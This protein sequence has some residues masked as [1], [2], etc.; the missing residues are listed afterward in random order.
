MDPTVYLVFAVVFFLQ[1]PTSAVVY[2]DAKKRKLKHPGWYELGVLVPLGGLGIVAAY[3]YK[4]R[5]LP[6]VSS[7]TPQTAEAEPTNETS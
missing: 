1:I 3:L 7:D 2:F 6:T 5:D 4:R